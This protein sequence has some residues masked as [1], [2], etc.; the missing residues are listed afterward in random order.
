[1]RKYIGFTLVISLLANTLT[2]AQQ[3]CDLKK[4][5]NDIK[6]YLCENETQKFKTIIVELEMPATLSQY[7]ALVLD[8][9]NSD[10][11][12]YKVAKQEVLKTLSKT[13]LYYYSEVSPPWPVS[14]R[15]VIFHMVL[16]QDPVSLGLT[17]TLEGMPNYLPE[18]DGVVRLPFAKS[19]LN[20]DPIDEENVK[21]RY[22]LDVNPGGEV[23]AW[24]INFFAPN[25]PW[26][27]Y[28]NFRELI[29]AQGTN[30]IEV[31]FI[32]NFRE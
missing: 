14:N 5:A 31:S 19:T 24:V 25:A 4:S 11:W 30:R 16:R 20:V 29:K 9:K 32:K 18:N 28:N 13:E 12:Q 15:D 6:V 2:F 1:M 3:D 21:V 7:A 10:K 17:V 26:H 8:V 22:E 23:P 27:T